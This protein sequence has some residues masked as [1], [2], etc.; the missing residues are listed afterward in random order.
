MTVGELKRVLDKY[1]LS[2][3]A[4]GDASEVVICCSEGN[5][6]CYWHY[7]SADG[8]TDH[9][10]DGTHF[11]ITAEYDPPQRKQLSAGQGI[12]KR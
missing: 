11:T 10:F 9:P 12:V 1:C 6:C 5:Y 3:N 7:T 2:R 4:N 8:R